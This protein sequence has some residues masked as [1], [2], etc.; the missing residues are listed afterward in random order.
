ML[1]T[2]PTRVR[3]PATITRAPWLTV[4]TLTRPEYL[5]QLWQNDVVVR[6]TVACHW[7]T[8]TL[9]AICGMRPTDEP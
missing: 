4:Q 6:L 8:S 9:E 3:L 1:V 2:N 5:R 7:S